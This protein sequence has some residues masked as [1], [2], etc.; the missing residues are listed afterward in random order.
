MT[1]QVQ[2][3]A[4]EFIRAVYIFLKMIRII[5]VV[6]MLLTGIGKK[7]LN[8]AVFN[9]EQMEPGIQGSKIKKTYSKSNV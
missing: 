7:R 3:T 9:Q 8:C 6:S 2:I 1:I 5:Q 4:L